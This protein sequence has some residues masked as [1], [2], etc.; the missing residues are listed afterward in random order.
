MSI[1]TTVEAVPNRMRDVFNYV[2]S[3]N[4]P[5]DKED[6]RTLFMP[7]SK[8]TNDS[9]SLIDGAL[10]ECLNIGL[11]VED[12]GIQVS[13][14]VKNS[15]KND[16]R[17]LMIELLFQGEHDQAERH[18][19]VL[20][21]IAWLMTRK[22]G[23]PLNFSDT[24]TTQLNNS[25]GDNASMTEIAGSMT[26]LHNLYYWCWYLGFGEI[27]GGS[28]NR[29][30][31]KLF[32]PNPVAILELKLS[33]I[34]EDSMVLRIDDFLKKLGD[35]IPVLDGG[36]IRNE[37]ELALLDQSKTVD[38]NI[39][40]TLSYAIK[41]LALKKKISFEKRSDARGLILNYGQAMRNESVSEIRIHS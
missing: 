32:M 33:V 8:R 14:F 18:K 39:S 26:T 38:E 21:T 37:V 10:K 12:N 23:K 41:Q 4:N 5:I 35:V 27:F 40:E 36:N 25:L 20:F 9:S 24:I 30:S 15:D 1:L 7:P 34:F 2:K 22:P 13:S 28:K 19:K 31:V 11:L 16:F 3:Q 6:L 29:D 17:D